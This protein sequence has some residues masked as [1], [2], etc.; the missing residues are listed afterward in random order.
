MIGI[1]LMQDGASFKRFECMKCGK[2]CKIAAHIPPVEEA[3]LNLARVLQEMPECPLM[4]YDGTLTI[5]RY[6]KVTTNNSK[7]KSQ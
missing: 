2:E 7:K 1:A 4:V 3:L 6:E 5:L